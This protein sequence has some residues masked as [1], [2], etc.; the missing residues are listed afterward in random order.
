MEGK[1]A[2]RKRIAAIRD[3]IPPRKRLER[4]TA[5]ARRLCQWDRFAAAKTIF[6]FLSTGSEVS[7]EPIVALAL[8]EGKVVGAP[9]TLLKEKRL[10]FRRLRGARGEFARGPFG[11]REPKAAAPPLK[12]GAADL[13]L[14][15]GLAFDRRG[16]RVGYG[17]GFYDWLLGAIRPDAATAGITF[18]EQIVERVPTT[19]RDRPV[20]WIVT[21]KRLIACR[22]RGRG[23]DED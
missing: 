14:V 4:S 22:A 1:S 5:I 9:R 13:I 2:L 16:Y 21:D 7:T 12:P 19:Q 18:E 23:D 8:V 17:G 10:E 20:R 3:S 11:I 15:P 6:V